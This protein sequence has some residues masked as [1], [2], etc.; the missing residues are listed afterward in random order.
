MGGIR[1]VI[2]ER[3]KSVYISRDTNRAFVLQFIKCKA[4]ATSGAKNST[5]EG[6]LLYKFSNREIKEESFKAVWNMDNKHYDVV[7]SSISTEIGN[8][9]KII[10]T[11]NSKKYNLYNDDSYSDLKVDEVLEELGV[12]DSAI[13][14]VEPGSKPIKVS[15]IKL[16]VCTHGERGSGFWDEVDM[17]FIELQKFYGFELTI[18]R[19][20]ESAENQAAFLNELADKE[21][22]GYTAMCS[23][24]LRPEIGDA[25]R[26]LSVRIPTV[27]YNTSVSSIPDAIEYVGAGSSGEEQQGFDLAIHMG[28][29]FLNSPSSA[30]A[31]ATAYTLSD[32]T[33]D[34]SL[35]EEFIDKLNSYSNLLVISHTEDLDNTAFTD[36]HRGATRIFENAVYYRDFNELKDKVSEHISLHEG[37]TPIVLGM[38]LQGSVLDSLNEFLNEFIEQQSSLNYFLGVTD[39]TSSIL[40]QLNDPTYL[41][42]VSGFPPIAQGN[43]VSAALLNKV[44]GIFGGDIS[45]LK[46]SKSLFDP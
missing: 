29:I 23:T 21:D 14:T 33:N 20:G 22:I 3:M 6:T 30:S 5:L 18:E 45:L 17:A 28:L 35:R 4:V 8:Q 40:S 26:R 46:K 44:Y 42:A 12:S 25:V 19:F 41:V 32:I 39:I 36:R 31:S 11:Y 10:V 34:F 38:C 1:H 43:L 16:L 24:V 7:S 27:T 2:R 13:D 9:E 15:D 37:N